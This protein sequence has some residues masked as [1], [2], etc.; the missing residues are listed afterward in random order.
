MSTQ[1]YLAAINCPHSIDANSVTIH[2][3]PKEPGNNA[4][5]QLARRLEAAGST[6][7]AHATPRTVGALE[8]VAVFLDTRVREL[9]SLS[10]EATALHSKV[11]A[12]LCESVPECNGSHDDG[13]IV[14]GDAACT[15]CGGDDTAH[16]LSS[17]ANAERLKRSVAEIEAE[18]GPGYKAGLEALELAQ[19]WEKLGVIV[20]IERMPHKPLAMGHHYPQVKTWPKRGGA[21]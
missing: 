9:G 14:A 13:Q 11:R 15:A 2:F 5:D 21:E 20:T 3:D 1:L 6:P 16:L 12:A 4:L 17:P 18:L 8:A 7:A 19:K 10:P